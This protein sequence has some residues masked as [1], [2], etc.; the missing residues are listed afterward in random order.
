MAPQRLKCH[1]E[2]CLADDEDSSCLAGCF[3]P[4][5]TTTTSTT[6]TTTTTTTSTTTEAIV[7]NPSECDSFWDQG[8]Y[9]EACAYCYEYT[10]EHN[11]GDVTCTLSIWNQCDPYFVDHHGDGCDWYEAR[12]CASGYPTNNYLAYA[13]YTATEGLKTGLVC[14][15]CGCSA[16]TGPISLD[17]N[18]S[19]RSMDAFGPSIEELRN[20]PKE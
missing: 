12:N 11:D 10:T 18:S 9:A 15:G 16:E 2:I 4:T 19:T 14:P 5:T 3:E 13:S 8:H 6:T 20:N 7:G 17:E 1:V